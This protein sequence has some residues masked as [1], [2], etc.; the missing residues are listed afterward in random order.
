MPIFNCDA[1]PGDNLEMRDKVLYVNQNPIKQ[2]ELPDTER[3]N[4]LKNSFFREEGNQSINIFREFMDG[5]TYLIGVDPNSNFSINFSPETIPEDRYFVLGDTRDNSKDSRFWGF[6]PLKN[7]E[8]KVIYSYRS[9]LDI[10][11]K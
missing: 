11:V 7:I 1:I 6:V 2:Q 4:I 9:S 5:S 3:Q 8:G 10:K